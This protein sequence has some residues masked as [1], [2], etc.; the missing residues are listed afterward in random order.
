MPPTAVSASPL[1]SVDEPAHPGPPI[2]LTDRVA[3][4]KDKLRED[5][6]PRIVYNIF[7]RVTITNT[8]ALPLI[9][10]LFL[11]VTGLPKGVIPLGGDKTSLDPPDGLNLFPGQS[12]TVELT[13]LNQGKAPI[14]YTAKMFHGRVP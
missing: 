11:A 5:Q 14:E 12:V 6:N 4:R 2:D 9:G 10:P 1:F 8:T 3:I 13:F 7:Q